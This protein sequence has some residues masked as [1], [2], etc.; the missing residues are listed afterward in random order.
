MFKQDEIKKV[1][2]RQVLR[3]AIS[4]SGLT[5]DEVS[6]YSLI[7]DNGDFILNPLREDLATKRGFSGYS[8]ILLGSA[9]MLPLLSNYFDNKDYTK[10]DLAHD[11]YE[12]LTEKGFTEVV[13]KDEQVMSEEQED[14]LTRAF[15][16]ECLNPLVTD[17]ANRDSM[18]NLTTKF[19]KGTKD[20]EHESLKASFLETVDSIKTYLSLTAKTSNNRERIETMISNY[21]YL[22]EEIVK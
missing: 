22:E 2:T 3:D 5:R 21:N 19:L 11:M 6:N 18:V 1:L 17:S 15:I 7:L 10:N 8:T 9:E 20:V 16:I 4:H 13:I 12:L 14:N